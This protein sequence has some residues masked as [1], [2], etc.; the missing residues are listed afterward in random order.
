[1]KLVLNYAA[2]G[3]RPY[4]ELGEFVN[5]GVLAVEPRSRFLAYRLSTPQR[6]R[7]VSAC[8]PEL[9]LSLYRNG[10][11]RLEKELATLV[12]ET[13]LWSDEA[14]QAGRNH[15]AQSDLFAE[16]EGEDLFSRLAAPQ[17]SPFFCAARG[18]RLC[19]DVAAAV[20]ALYERFVEHRHL[21][22]SDHEEK[23]LTREIRQLLRAHRLGRLYREAPW[24]GTDAY[25]V[26]IPLAFTPR[27]A[28]TPAKAIKPLNLVRSTPT[29][30]YTYG[31]EWIAKVHRL[32]RVGCLPQ[33]FLFVVKM[34]EDGEERVAAEEICEGLAREG[35]AV[36]EI[37][38]EE[39]ILAFARIEEPPE[40]TLEG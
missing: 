15:P 22:P 34:P 9:D 19:E 10:L 29:P 6:T 4:P 25:H 17:D 23:Q 16:A 5:V 20:D 18:T 7:R 14:R 40:L 39:A 35:A 37:G 1:M 27:G 2:I 3:Y 11:R 21:T 13:N 12:I 26:G 32:R 8:F 31:D 38:D 28:E 36:A 24:V 33:E 30:I